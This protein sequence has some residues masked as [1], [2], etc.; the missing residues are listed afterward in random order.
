M[1]M[2]YIRQQYGVPAKRGARVRFTPDGNLSTSCDGI[3][4][5]TRNGYL[6]VRMGEERRVRTYHPTW[7]IEYVS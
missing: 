7:Q 5:G 2:K 4:V 3:I 1:G 6:R